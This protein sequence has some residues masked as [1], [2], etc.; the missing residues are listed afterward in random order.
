MNQFITAFDDYCIHQT[1]D[2][3][4]QPY[5][6][7]RNFYDRYW[8]NGFDKDGAF[9]FEAG[10]GI[11]PNRHIMDGH[12]SIVVDGVQHAFHS[13]RRAP[14]D[15]THTT[16]GPLKI[17]VVEP[18]RKIRIVIASNDTGIECDL[19]FHARSAPV[20]EDKNVMR[21]GVRIIMETTRFTQYGFWQGY[22]S[23]QGKKIPV[24]LA[25][26]YGTRDK[27]WGYRPIGEGEQGA[28]GLLNKEPG[29]YWV[30][31][32]IHFKDFCTHYASFQD[33]DGK[34]TQ[35]GGAIV[36]AYTSQA[37][38]P[39]QET[40]LEH[41]KN[42]SHS[43]KWRKG[44]RWASSSTVHLTDKNNVRYD[45]ELTPLIRFQMLAIGYQHPQ[46]GHAVWKGEESFAAESWKMD[47]IDPLD[48]KHIHVH[49]V[50]KAKLVKTDSQGKTESHEG[51]GTFE[52]V[53]FGRHPSGFKDILDGAA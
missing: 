35:E 7:E 45:M 44:T 16:A 48:Y 14:L 43:L 31:S 34:P 47:E 13:S 49:H 1:T 18:M 22:V 11:Y 2:P 5:S 32:P 8:F 52:T 42:C 9:I 12:F 4:A 26:T 39:A 20:Q 17:E 3:L 15:R 30:W 27:S 25:T 33:F 19:T 38:I 40:H 10:L 24:N 36:P 41:I 28:P 50:V 23:I 37:D 51:I 29:V 21:E 46:W 53:C 6:A